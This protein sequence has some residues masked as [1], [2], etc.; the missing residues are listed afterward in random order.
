[1]THLKRFCISERCLRITVWVCHHCNEVVS[2]V[3]EALKMNINQQVNS[4]NM[5]NKNKNMRYTSEIISTLHWAKIQ[6]NRMWRHNTKCCEEK[7]KKSDFI[8]IAQ[9]CLY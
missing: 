1:M 9:P 6:V 2:D 3:H 7:Q 5:L 4:W 8:N